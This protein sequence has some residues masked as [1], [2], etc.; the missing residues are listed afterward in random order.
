MA[1]LFSSC[2]LVFIAQK[3]RVE[4]RELQE[5]KWVDSIED[6]YENSSRFQSWEDLWEYQLEKWVRWFCEGD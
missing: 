5:A 3:S 1:G 4:A 2:E 6:L